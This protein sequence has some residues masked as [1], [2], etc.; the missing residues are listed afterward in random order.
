MCLY[1]ASD[2][3]LPVERWFESIEQREEPLPLLQRQREQ[4]LKARLLLAQGEAGTAIEQLERLSA[5]AQETSHFTLAREAQVVLV[6][7]Y[8]HEGRREKGQRQLLELLAKTRNEN[9]LRLYLDQGEEMADHLRGILPRIAEKTVLTYARRILNAFEK[10]AG[11]SDGQAQ[12]IEPVLPE[13]L[14]AQERKVLRL[15]AAGNSNA[16]IAREL[17]VS[18]NTIR[19]QVQSIYR[20]LN[21][22]NRVEASEVARRSGWA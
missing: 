5:A 6:L 7:A 11:P 3:L 1:L 10:S 4:L 22:N 15:L 16:E 19:T 2:D 18:V 14:S 9:Y 20:K 13:P 8:F 21:V 12:D 17:V